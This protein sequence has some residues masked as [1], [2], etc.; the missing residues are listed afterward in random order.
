MTGSAPQGYRP[1]IVGWTL[2]ALIFAVFYVFYKIS[3]PEYKQVTL[4]LKG[5]NALAFNLFCF[6]TFMALIAIFQRFFNNGSSIAQSFA[7]CSYAIYYVHMY[8]VLGCAYLFLPLALPLSV[9][10]VVVTI[11]AVLCSW[12]TAIL[13]RKTPVLRGDVLEKG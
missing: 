11:V 5:G 10:F 13:M 4:L 2:P 12:G 8:F 9:K 3:V 6:S 1:R 7:A